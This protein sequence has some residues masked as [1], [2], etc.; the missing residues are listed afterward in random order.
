[1]GDQGAEHY[2]RQAKPKSPWHVQGC[3]KPRLRGLGAE[4][5]ILAC[6]CTGKAETTAD[7]KS[8]AGRQDTRCLSP[9]W[10]EAWA[11]ETLI[12]CIHQRSR[13]ISKSWTYLSI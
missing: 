3:L 9:M 2:I 1:M 5:I 7:P 13:S 11:N 6:Q 4:K 10:R 8:R 12:S